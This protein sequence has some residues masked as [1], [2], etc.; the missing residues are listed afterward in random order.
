M[1]LKK[2][3]L[4]IFIIFIGV[5]CSKKQPVYELIKTK[6]DIDFKTTPFSEY[7]FLALKNKKKTGQ[8]DVDLALAEILSQVKDLP[9]DE[10]KISKIDRKN[11]QIAKHIYEKDKSNIESVLIYNYQIVRKNKK[12]LFFEFEINFKNSNQ[13]LNYL[14]IDN[15]IRL[16]KTKKYIIETIYAAKYPGFDEAKSTYERMKKKLKILLRLM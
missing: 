16:V 1:M 2:L 6:L 11:M 8:K 9:K 3:F 14:S 5:A 4:F 15:E 12:Y 10:Y 7:Y 13:V